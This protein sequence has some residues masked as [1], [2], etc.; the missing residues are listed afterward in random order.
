MQKTKHWSEWIEAVRHVVGGANGGASSDPL[1]RIMQVSEDGLKWAPLQAPQSVVASSPLSPHSAPHSAPQGC[2][3]RL[4]Q[5]AGDDLGAG[6]SIYDEIA[7]G[8][9]MVL[10]PRAMALTPQDLAAVLKSAPDG[11]WGL[12]FHHEGAANLALA[13]V[14]HD[15]KREVHF[16][17]DPLGDCLL[18]DAG[19][20][21]ARGEALAQWQKRHFSAL[22][23]ARIF[24]ASGD[25][26]HS[27]GLSE[28]Q[29]LAW[30]LANLVWQLRALEAA[31]LTL[32]E[33]C[34]R[35]VMRVAVGADVY[36]ALA[37]TRAARFLLARLMAALDVVPNN[38]PLLHVMTSA[39]MLTR[40]EPMNNLLRHTTAS[41]GGALG[42]ADILTTLPHDWLTGS[43]AQ[44]RRLA[45]G[46]QLIM[47]H[48]ARLGE[49]ADPAY[50]AD[51]LEVM[52]QDIA[53]NAWQKFQDIEKA[54]GALAVL[55]SGQVAAW[56]KAAIERRQQKM[57]AGDAPALLGVNY[58]SLAPTAPLPPLVMEAGHGRGGQARL[59]AVW[60][61][62]RLAA[63]D[64]NLRALL[65][66]G[67][68]AAAA[69]W[70]ASW[71]DELRVLGVEI[72]EIAP[73][74]Q[75]ELKEAIAA[76]K[77]HLVV[78]DDVGADSWQ[79]AVAPTLVSATLVSDG[80]VRRHTMR[81]MIE[82]AG[83]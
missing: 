60:E 67:G 4:A 81:R 59:G 48:E 56:A 68:G 51:T 69:K 80:K 49:V 47:R 73:A 15:P 32:A 9:D 8:A 29:E 6:D 64:K 25:T 27:F 75:Q 30:V 43:T 46:V 52:S 41:L 34:A 35:L 65:V 54:G 44:S 38:T 28:V 70:R 45:R 42:G 71:R 2:G 39:R 17:G 5:H 10:I 19:D 63:N 78:G 79:G 12:G 72:A 13:E 23:K 50:G 61:D 1:A 18:G 14:W 77:P 20:V 7:G 24:V 22:P 66:V 40:I 11:A 3:W 58:Q 37:K 55:A 83:A 74:S 82:G 21:E 62:L 57:D 16:A 33:G 26:A 76:A 31:G 36:G 53:R